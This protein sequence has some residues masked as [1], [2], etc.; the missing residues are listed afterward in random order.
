MTYFDNTAIK[1]GQVIAKL[2]RMWRYVI[3]YWWCS[4]SYHWH[5]MP[6]LIIHLIVLMLRNYLDRCPNHSNLLYFKLSKVMH[7][8][9][10]IEPKIKLQSEW[11]CLF[12]FSYNP[13]FA[14]HVSAN[15]ALLGPV[16]LTS[17]HICV[18]FSLAKYYLYHTK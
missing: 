5:T 15:Y 13:W 16:V 7:C 8:I 10:V 17:S 12:K 1:T 4:Y 3:I 18:R 11:V 2:F 9:L 14:L 6:N